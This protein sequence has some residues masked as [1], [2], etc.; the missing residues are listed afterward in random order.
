MLWWEIRKDIYDRDNKL[1]RESYPTL[2]FKYDEHIL[3]LEGEIV[4][5]TISG[6][7]KKIKVKIVFPSDYPESA[8]KAYDVDKRFGGYTP[9]RHINIDNSFCL[10]LP[11]KVNIDFDKKHTILNFLDFLILFLRK[12]LIYECTGKWPGDEEPH[13][14]EALEKLYYERFIGSDSPEIR[15]KLRKYWKGN[16]KIGRNDRCPC[17]N[18]KRYKRCHL[19]FIDAMKSLRRQNIGRL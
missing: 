15:I 9:N 18:N 1:V 2:Q 11:E 17:G 10:Y 4:L 6:I 12:Q 8:P 13:G 14:V 3:S 19:L 5:K 16:L 7:P